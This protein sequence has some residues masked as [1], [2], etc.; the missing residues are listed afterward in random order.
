VHVEQKR[1]AEAIAAAEGKTSGEIV[2]VIT[3]ASAQY[4]YVPFLWA[5]LAVLLV[6]IPLIYWTWLP[7]Q[8][9]YYIQIAVFAAIL[10]I[11]AF[12]PLRLA[13]VP[14]FDKHRRAHHRAVEQFLTQNLHTTPGRTG[15]LI[16]I[17]V[18]ERFVEIL[19]DD[20]I[21]KR[22]PGIAWQTI[23]DDLTSHIRRGQA[24]EGLLRAIDGVG[25]LLA[26]HF[27]P[28]SANPNALPNHL[29][30]LPTEKRPELI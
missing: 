14:R 20:G 5:G 17:S 27:P 19:A 2:A 30:V 16:F 8:Q 25:K 7:T 4:L 29:I 21:D 18:A 11:L 9:I 13:L 6:P 28:G 26:E 24:C 15:V 12:R 22:V 3:P 1:V 10:L 23:V